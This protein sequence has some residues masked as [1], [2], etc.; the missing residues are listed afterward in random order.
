MKSIITVRDVMKQKAAAEAAAYEISLAQVAAQQNVN[1]LLA[2][3]PQVGVLNRNGKAVYY[4]NFP[5]Y[6]EASTPAALI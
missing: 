4:V 1:A 5:D 6:R 3:N 2:A